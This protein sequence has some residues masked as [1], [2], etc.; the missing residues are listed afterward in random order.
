V[1]LFDLGPRQS[2][3]LL[4]LIHH[5][6]VDG[7]AWRILL[8][9]L[10]TAY[11]QVRR[12][13]NA[14]LPPKTTSFRDWAQKLAAYAR[15]AEL[16]QELG[17][18]LA[19]ARVKTP[20]LLMDYPVGPE[21]NTEASARVVSVSLTAEETQALLHEVPTAYRTQINDLL[22]TALAQSFSQWTESRT[23]LVDLEGHGREAIFDDVD[24]SRTVGWFTTIFPAL[25]NLEAWEPGEALKSIKEQLRAI[26][27]RGVGYGLLRYLSGDEEIAA[28]LRQSPQAEVSFN[29]LGQ[30]DQLLPEGAL[31]GPATES[32][33]PA[34]SPRGS[35]QCIACEDPAAIR[36]RSTRSSPGADCSW[37]GL[38]A[39]AFIS[40]RQSNIWL[41][42]IHRLCVRSSP[43]ACLQ[44]QAVTRPRTSRWR[45]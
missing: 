21:A 4:I 33:G 3:R 45:I 10:M 11:Q 27:N 14:Q 29:Y 34:R 18:W 42:I 12:G 1:A 20:R 36:W 22:L 17:Y 16:K 13:E 6:A 7:V 15:T 30:F 23:L 35:G 40:T 24:L 43:I 39:S 19:P 9:D 25:L 44:Q 32:V 37:S 8:E 41:R 38:T 28:R 31:F 26:P 2:S 5:L